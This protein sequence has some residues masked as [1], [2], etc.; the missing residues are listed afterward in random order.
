M[1]THSSDRFLG[2]ERG[3][4]S[5]CGRWTIYS[6]QIGRFSSPVLLLFMGLNRLFQPLCGE[7]HKDR[8]IFNTMPS[9]R[10]IGKWSHRWITLHNDDDGD[11]DNDN[12]NSDN[13][14]WYAAIFRGKSQ[15]AGRY[16]ALVLMIVR[17]CARSEK[18]AEDHGKF[19]NFDN[20][21]CNKWTEA[22]VSDT[23]IVSTIPTGMH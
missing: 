15:R 20:E 12:N 21:P 3:F 9:I 16:T 4:G 23:R 6:S 11:E 22:Q 17:Y 10:L 2:S 14:Y 18:C 5:R 1:F 8:W 19:N 13:E 7:E